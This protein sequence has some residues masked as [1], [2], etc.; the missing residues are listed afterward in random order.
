MK[1]TREEYVKSKILKLKQNPNDFESENLKLEL[2][3]YSKPQDF[4]EYVVF[5]KGGNVNVCHYNGYYLMVIRGDNKTKYSKLP[6]NVFIKKYGASFHTKFNNKVFNSVSFDNQTTVSAED[7]FNQRLLEL[8]AHSEDTNDLKNIS[9][10]FTLKDILN[11]FQ[12]H[13]EKI[14]ANIDFENIIQLKEKIANQKREIEQLTQLGSLNKKQSL[15]LAILNREKRDLQE[16]NKSHKITIS[17][18]SKKLQN[19]QQLFSTHSNKQN[20]NSEI[21][22]SQIKTEYLNIGT[23]NDGS[24]GWH[25]IARENGKFGS[26]PSFDNY[27]DDY[28]ENSK[29]GFE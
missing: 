26:L 20:D 14:K 8:K 11:E 13:I 19:C 2:L 15:H 4:E 1:F 22:L 12:S 6:I 29:E 10:F 23:E 27:D 24:K 25:G 7:Y 21:P 5:E 18:I 17:D 28:L 16:E 3:N 9:F